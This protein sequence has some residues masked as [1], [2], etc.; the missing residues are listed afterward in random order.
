MTQDANSI[1]INE[2][3]DKLRSLTDS[4]KRFKRDEAKP[5]PKSGKKVVPPLPFTL[6]KDCGAYAAKSHILKGI[7]AKRETSGWIGPPGSGKSAL[8]TE[9]GFHT[10]AGKDWRGH[11]S[12]GVFGVVIFALERADLYRRR[13]EVYKRCTGLNDLPVA[14]V[15]CIINAMSPTVADQIE[16]TVRAIEAETGVLVGLVI[17]DTYPKAIAAGGGDEDKAAS[18]NRAAAN[19]R[20]VHERLDV[21]IALVGHT[22]KDESKGA[23]GSSAHLGDVDVMTQVSDIAGVKVATITKG[24]DTA[25][26]DIA[27]YKLEL[28]ELDRDEDGDPITTTIVSVEP[29][30]QSTPRKTVEP[31]LTKNQTT[32]FGLLHDAGAG[33][34]LTEEWN[35]RGRH[36]GIGVHRR[37]DLVDLRSALKSKNLVRQM[38]DRWS[39]DHGSSV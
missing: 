13:L 36:A 3:T 18:V 31:K 23:R 27:T 39:I 37:A 2:G 38:G 12:K 21:H 29:I 34:L 24:N 22:G 5:P 11:R 33:G 25:E 19:L 17:I 7:L 9:I 32:M 35:E 4:A 15:D 1:L 16:A 26:R 28:V 10:A 6:F 20:R 8:L 30:D 14:V